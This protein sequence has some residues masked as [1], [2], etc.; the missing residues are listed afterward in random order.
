LHNKRHD[1][2]SPTSV[3]RLTKYKWMRWTGQVALMGREGDAL[4]ILMGKSENYDQFE[5]LA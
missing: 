2:C 1:S 4:R 5:D 3:T